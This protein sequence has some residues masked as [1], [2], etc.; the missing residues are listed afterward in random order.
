V[1]TILFIIEYSRIGII[2]NVLSG[3][4]YQSNVERSIEHRHLLLKE[5]E[6]TSILLLH[7]F[8]FFGTANKLLNQIRFRLEATHL[9]ALRY[10]ILDFRAVTGFDSSALHSFIK[11]RQLAI[12][13]NFTLILTHLSVQLQHQLGKEFDSGE[14]DTVV[15]FFDDLDDGVTWCEEQILRSENALESET[16]T[17]L[18]MQLRVLIPE[19][20]VNRLM[21]YLEQRKVEKNYHLMRQGEASKGM[22]FIE[23][24]QT[25]AQIRTAT[26]EVTRL[27][28]MGAGSIVG[29]LGL[30]LGVPITA[31][32]IAETTS[33][34]YHLSADALRQMEREDQELASAFHK[35]I[36][37]TLGERLINTNKCWIQL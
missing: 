19:V 25:R 37:R 35:F 4:T 13:K 24:G 30:Y 23:S 21:H 8:I 26:G 12:A 20:N 11:I 7:G 16:D 18:E 9:V 3:A 10:L 14:R 28:M 17:S 34:L 31:T 33:V 36:V 32:V 5:G 22:F 29:D 15:K 1:A 2:K 6:Q 27:R